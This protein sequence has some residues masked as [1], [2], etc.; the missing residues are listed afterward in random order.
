MT[1]AVRLPTA[2]GPPSRSAAR[3]ERQAEPE[4][5][6]VGGRVPSGHQGEMAHRCRRPGPGR[7]DLR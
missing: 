6:V 3:A 1:A 5:R 4:K 7:A 2:R